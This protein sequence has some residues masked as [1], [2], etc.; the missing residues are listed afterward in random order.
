VKLLETKTLDHHGIVAGTCEELGIKEIVDKL[1][2]KKSNQKRSFGELIVAMI[3]NGL[4]FTTQPL[5]LTPRF[6]KDKPV[7]ILFGENINADDFNDDALGRCL[8]TLYDYGC[9]ILFSRVSY[10]VCKDFGINTKFQ[11]LD[12]SVMQL[13]GKYDT[14]T[15]LLRFGRPKNGRQDV[16][17]FLISMMVSNDGGVPLLADV[18][19]GNTSDAKHFR[20]VLKTL[21]DSMKESTEQIYHVA[22]AALYNKESLKELAGSPIKFITRVP[23][24]LRE[25]KNLFNNTSIDSMKEYNDNYR[26]LELGNSYGEVKQRWLLVFSKAAYEKEV[27]TLHFSLKKERKQ[28]RKEINKLSRRSFLCKEDG[29]KEIDSLLAKSK[30]HTIRSAS[31]EEKERKKN[32]KTVF[33]VS[34]KVKLSKVDVA[35]HKKQKGKFIVATNELNSDNLT[36][37]EILGYYK[38]QSTVERGFRFLNNPLCMADAVYL[39]N[40]KRIKALVTVMCLCLLVYSVTQ[41]NLRKTLI[42][43][44]LTIKNQVNKET[45]K[46]TLKWIFQLFQGI[47]VIY[48]QSEKQINKTVSNICDVRKYILQLLGPKYQNKYLSFQLTCG[49]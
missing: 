30:F 47:H 27:K 39:K 19:A 15:E 35:Y 9:D 7:E 36:D 20:K 38:D 13:E 10:E 48:Q 17:Q 3:I 23:N 24:F 4:G 14:A 25:A 32:P 1:I 12:T 31:I 29:Q 44:N 42:K 2:P 18:V 41:R 45:Q 34:L 46:P 8:D 43:R 33:K 21:G 40:E 26:T 5:Y 49:M 37:K 28:L 11:H 22:D 16:K 6:F